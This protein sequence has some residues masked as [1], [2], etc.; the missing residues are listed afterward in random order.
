MAVQQNHKSRSRRDMRR[1][2]DALSAMTLSVDK[3]SEEVHIRHNI[4]EGGYYRGEKLNLTPAEPL[5]SKKEFLASRK[6]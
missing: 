1:S 4:T 3:T 2:H 6:K 5:M